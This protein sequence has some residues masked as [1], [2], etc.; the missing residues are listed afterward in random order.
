MYA[1]WRAFEG[2]DLGKESHVFFHSARDAFSDPINEKH[3][4]YLGWAR[5]S[6]SRLFCCWDGGR[7]DQ[8]CG[9][10][11][12]GRVQERAGDPQWCGQCGVGRVQDRVG[13]PQRCGQCRV[14]RVQDR[15]VAISSALVT[16]VSRPAPAQAPAV[17]TTCCMA[18]EGALAACWAVWASLNPSPGLYLF[19]LRVDTVILLLPA[20]VGDKPSHRQQCRNHRGSL[21]QPGSK[22]PCRPNARSVMRQKPFV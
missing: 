19:P 4:S 2:S 7:E 9:Q 5:L 13:D 3:P 8:R 14:G 22:I 21:N 1:F 17:S 16:P 11:G 15:A 18:A 20:S 10:C 12:V 6:K